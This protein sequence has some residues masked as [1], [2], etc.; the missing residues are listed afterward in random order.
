M[1]AS[2]PKAFTGTVFI[3]F[4]AGKEISRSDSEADSSLPRSGIIATCHHQAK[5]VFNPE[6][7]FQICLYSG[8]LTFLAIFKDSFVYVLCVCVKDCMYFFC[9]SLVYLVSVDTESPGL[10]LQVK[11]PG[12]CWGPNWGPLQER[13]MLLV[14]APPLQPQNYSI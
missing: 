8:M 4:F 14:T 1:Q 2:A 12:G 5:H 9:A 7:D 11:L 10:E 6:Q 3:V 13:R